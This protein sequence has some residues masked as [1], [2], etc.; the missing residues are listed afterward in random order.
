MARG[1]S[2]AIGAGVVILLIAIGI[3]YV[4]NN[5][6]VDDNKQQDDTVAADPK[7]GGAG[8]EAV[9]NA[10]LGSVGSVRQIAAERER[11]DETVW[12]DEVMAQKYEVPFITL[13]DKMRASQDQF[14]ELSE[15][16]FEDLTVGLPGDPA[17][18]E[19]GIDE[20]RCDNGTKTFDPEQWKKWLSDWKDSGLRVVQSE[21]HHSRFEPDPE[22][23]R[24]VVSFVLDLANDSEQT[25]YNVR[26]KLA[27]QWNPPATPSD[28]P[29]ARSIEATDVTVLRRESSPIFEEAAVVKLNSK[30]RLPLAAIDLDG[31]GLSE[32]VSPMENAVY[33]NRGD[34]QFDQK[35]LFDF[36]PPTSLGYSGVMA[37]F[38]GDGKADFLGSGTNGVVFLFTADEDGRFPTRATPVFSAKDIHEPTVFTAGD[39]DADG[40]L[41]VWIG[42]YKQPYRGGQMPTPYFDANDG[43]PAYLLRNKGD[44]TFEDITEWSGLTEKRNRRTYSASLVDL[45]DDLDLDLVVVSDFSGVDVY[46]NDGTGKFRDITDEHIS[47]R[48]A[49]GMSVSFSD[50]DMDSKLDFFMTGM[51]STTAKRLHQMGLGQE[52]FEEYQSARPEMGYGNRLYLAEGQDFNQAPFNDQV[53]RTGWSWGSTSFDFD[54]DGDRDIFVAN[55]NNSQKTAKDYCTSFWCHDIYTGSSNYDPELGEFFEVNTKKNFGVERI[56]WNGFEHNVLLMNQNGKGFLRIDFLAGVSSELDS[57]NVIS[58]DFN[59]DGHVDLL[60]RSREP[61]NRTWAVHFL[62]NNDD[63]KANWIGVRLDGASRSGIGARVTVKTPS[64]THVAPVVSGDSYISQH[65]PVVHFGLGSET[66]VEEIEIKWPDGTVVK[67]PNPEI[68]RYH[69][70]QPADIKVSA[71]NA[72]S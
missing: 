24:S 15:F 3:V 5:R 55:G 16:S 12:S 69:R 41:D 21:W 38:T 20:F 68:N 18:H 25:F 13:W 37:D 60:V 36:P 70:I 2:K 7:D 40:D 56:S 46:T 33:W 28:Q 1:T 51:S 50:Y 49:F 52:Q 58:D 22:S 42:Q 10:G 48:H 43:H 65:A 11:L 6:D 27:V 44:G 4:V 62:K 67:I 26:G 17:Q 63:L 64:Q 39:I 47:N 23:P 45:D 53:A 34:F 19:H 54:N 59:G 29:T 8:G 71:A 30:L 72:G 14:V 66:Q 61:I 9:V 57:R 32:V 35:E 31:D